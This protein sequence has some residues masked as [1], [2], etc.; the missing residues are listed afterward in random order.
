MMPPKSNKDGIY[1]QYTILVT[2]FQSF[3]PKID[4]T[5]KTKSDNQKLNLHKP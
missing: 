4:L 1:Q 5:G 3:Y 2:C